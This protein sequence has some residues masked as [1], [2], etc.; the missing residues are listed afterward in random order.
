MP[1][2][3][4]GGALTL[5]ADLVLSRVGFG[6][7]QLT[8]PRAFGPHRDRDEAIAVLRAAVDL[9]V[10]HIDTADFYGPTSVNDLIRAALH[11]YPDDLRIVTKV[12]ARRTADGGFVH[13]RTAAELATQVHE[14]L[15]HLGL[16]VLD[17]VYLR[18]S[19]EATG[20]D[21]V[22]EE[23]GALAALRER[24]LVRHLGISGASARQLTEAQ[25]VAPVVAVQN[26]YNLAERGDDDLVD[27]CEREGI[28]FAPFFP[29]GG[30]DR[31]HPLRTDALGRVA[32]RLSASV[33]QVALAWLL[34]RSSTM[35]IIPGTSSV[36]H[37]RE[38]VA[39]A[40]LVLPPD[41][42]AEIDAAVD[43]VRTS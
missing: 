4:P 2:P 25:A 1:T 38:N 7:M 10:T 14:N 28:A 12:G 31:S 21:P 27:R 39:A 42:V 11:P 19:V 17:V 24:G 23:F 26:Y 13:A 8:G 35:T 22:A 37:L 3:M 41:A 29:L 32:V 40:D 34:R 30:Q 5:A 16:D 6:A 20:E 36:A 15:D 33:Q 18:L 43:G 9:G